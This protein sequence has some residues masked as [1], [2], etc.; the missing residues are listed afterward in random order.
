MGDPRRNVE[1]ASFITRQ[2]PKARSILVVADGK[3]ELARKLANKGFKVRVIEDKPR[4]EGRIHKNIAYTRGWF[5]ADT[6][7]HEDLVVG[8][9][10]D[11]ATAEIIHAAHAQGKAWAVVPCCVVGKFARN[12]GGNYQ[13]WLSRLKKIDPLCEENMLRISGKNIVLFRRGK[14]KGA[15]KRRHKQTM[16]TA[17][18]AR[19]V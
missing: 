8:M 4:F 12:L 18:S 6:R 15:R 14:M 11:E 19:Y 1:F 16:Q 5:S 13:Q 9:H 3:G 7:I 17:T 2:F 10:P